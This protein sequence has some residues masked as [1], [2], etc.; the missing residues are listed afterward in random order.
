M[1]MRIDLTCPVEAWKAT[2]PTQ[3]NPACEV[4]LF[5][6]SSLQV[7]S[8]EVTLLLSSQDG[9]ETAKIIHRSRGLNGAPGKTFTMTVP[10]EGHITPERY[11]ITVEKV[12]FDNASVWRHERENTVTY[13][14]NNLRRSAQLTTL[15]AIAG[16][17]ASGYPEQQR[18]LWVCVCGRPNLDDALICAR[19]HREKEQVFARFSRE[20]IDAAV[21][22]REDELAQHG[23][24]TLHK[25]SRRFADEKDFVRRKKNH[26]G[27]IKLVVFVVLLAG[28]TFGAVK[29]GVP[30][31]Q[32]ELAMQ[33]YENGEY[34]AAAEQFAELGEYKDAARWNKY[35]LLCYENE[36]LRGR[37][38]RD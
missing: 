1:T 25:T 5:N 8:V 24:E 10:V 12:W 23:R 17:M 7:V 6:L 20:A 16:D 18:G 3:D 35:C 38:S 32:Y 34:A 37:R 2:L 15:R 31:M 9:E 11:E 33:T 36:H 28:L 14:P 22:A 27:L 13:T 4:T 26:G 30:Y 21:A 29:F 19:C